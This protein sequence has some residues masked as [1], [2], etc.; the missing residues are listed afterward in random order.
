MATGLG[1]NHGWGVLLALQV[2]EVDSP[3]L[4]FLPEMGERKRQKG[5]KKE[6]EWL[7]N[8]LVAPDSRGRP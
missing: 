6:R 5:R 1:V 8:T 4:S 7:R 2:G 3:T